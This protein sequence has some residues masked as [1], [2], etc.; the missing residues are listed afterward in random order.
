MEFTELTLRL[1]FI[2]FPGIITALVY[3]RLTAQP[4]KTAFF[5][6][7]YSFVYGMVTYLL[8]ALFYLWYTGIFYF[9][10]LQLDINKPV[11]KMPILF[12]SGLALVLVTILCYVSNNK[13]IFHFARKIKC[14][15]QTGYHSIWE[16]F[17]DYPAVEWVAVRDFRN[18]VLYQ[19][20]VD[21]FS[22]VEEDRELMLTNVM[23]FDNKE[24]KQLINEPIDAL[25]VLIPRSN[26]VVI[27]VT[28]YKK[29]EGKK[30]L[31]KIKGR[32]KRGLKRN[33]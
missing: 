12:A 4:Q 13:L 22:Q 16:E 31:K 26:D 10:P 28:E 14:S 18:N 17:F 6:L 25:L 9:F 29:E 33:H 15:R 32:V 8:L 23:I 27:E 24:G 19:G 5:F 1:L 20:R 2:F 7:V 11:D 21:S 3:D 30:C